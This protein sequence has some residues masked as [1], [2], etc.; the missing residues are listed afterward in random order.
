MSFL[1]LGLFSLQLISNRTSY[2]TIRG[3]KSCEELKLDEE[4]LEK[5][6]SITSSDQLMTSPSST[7]HLTS[8][9]SSHSH[10]SPSQFFDNSSTI[11]FNNEKNNSSNYIVFEKINLSNSVSKM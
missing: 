2:Y 10:Q 9:R 3:E 4:S 7:E 6:F 11:L 1:F 5:Y 8:I